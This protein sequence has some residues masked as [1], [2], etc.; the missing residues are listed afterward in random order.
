MASLQ[1]VREKTEPKDTPSSDDM[2]LRL[3]KLKGRVHGVHTQTAK[4]HA[5]HAC[6]AMACAHP[7]ARHILPPFGRS[8]KAAGA[9]F[10]LMRARADACG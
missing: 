3:A 1:V 6:C 8:G 5:T 7:A 2:R 10:N 9:V 4:Q